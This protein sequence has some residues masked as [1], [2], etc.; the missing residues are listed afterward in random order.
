MKSIIKIIFTLSIISSISFSC[1]SIR[2][3]KL[4]SNK[5]L[6]I[7]ELSEILDKDQKNRLK[8]IEM[9]KDTN[10]DCSTI[11]DSLKRVQVEIDRNNIRQL[12]KITKKYGFPNIER[13]GKP[14]PIWLVF[15]H[16]PEE[17][18]LEVQKLITKEH[19]QGRFPLAEYKM[20][21]WHLNGRKESFGNTE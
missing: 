21:Q 9:K 1:T 11:I 3:K 15:Q 10:N 17:Y 2:D 14:I 13:I 5:E 4:N 12:I 6:L 7:T 19:K 8:V 20:I 18:K 16:T